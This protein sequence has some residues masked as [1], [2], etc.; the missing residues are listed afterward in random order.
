MSPENEHLVMV[1]EEHVELDGSDTSNVVSEISAPFDPSKIRVETKNTQMDALIKRIKNNEIDLAPNFQRQAGV[2]TPR[3]QSLLIES[4]LIKIPL[5]AFYMDATDD[6]KWLVVD[7]LQRLTTIKRFVIDKEM[8]L[9]GMEFLTNYNGKKF[10]ELP[11][12]FQRRIEETDI[13]I[14]QIQPGTPDRVKFDIFRR[15]N[16]GGLD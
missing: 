16:T 12:N 7:G 2:W 3:T 15:I 13:V 14:Y 8:K 5:P 4:M 6:D 1:N 9:E 10:D 11:R